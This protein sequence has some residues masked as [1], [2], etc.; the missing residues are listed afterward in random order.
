MV[1]LETLLEE[2]KKGITLLE[3]DGVELGEELPQ[4][5]EV[6]GIYAKG[7]VVVAIVDYDKGYYTVSP[8][9][10]EWTLATTCDLVITLPHFLRDTWIVQL[11]LTSDLPE[12]YLKEKGFLY[13]GKLSESDLKLVREAILHGKELPKE[14]TGRG[15]SDPVHRA[16]K[17]FEYERHLDLYQSFL[18]SIGREFEEL[19]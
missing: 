17:T 5:Y 7:T 19:E 13:L 1:N 12:D 6:G 2:Y 14:R 15:H 4:T 3:K 8:V 16:F 18:E 10:F 11:D 9:S